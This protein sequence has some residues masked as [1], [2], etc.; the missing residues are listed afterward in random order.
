MCMKPDIKKQI[1]N[2]L[3]R[4]EGQIRGLHKMVDDDTY[5]ID[6]ITQTQAVKQALSS[7][8][9]K[10]LEEHLAT[11][12][13]EQMSGGESEKTIKEMMKVFKLA[14]KK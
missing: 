4:I 6:V 11:C 3:K 7:L 12:A 5:C 14:K 8:E 10:L 2:R 1:T 13:T 9:D